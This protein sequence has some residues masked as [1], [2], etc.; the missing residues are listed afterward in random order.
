[1]S[2]HKAPVI[3]TALIDISGQSRNSRKTKPSPSHKNLEK[4]TPT[5]LFLIFGLSSGK[6]V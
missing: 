4:E 1:M 5:N 6:L 2:R 3:N